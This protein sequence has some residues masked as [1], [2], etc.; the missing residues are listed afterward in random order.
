MN[1]PMDI[2]TTNLTPDFPLTLREF[3]GTIEDRKVDYIGYYST[4][5]DTII[6]ICIIL[7]HSPID[8]RA[9]QCRRTS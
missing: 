8:R 4:T 5:F 1:F 3:G 9:Q 7:L 2:G 6:T